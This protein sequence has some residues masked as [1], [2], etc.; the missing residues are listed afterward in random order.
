MRS[1]IDGCVS[2]SAY[3]HP[4]G[5]GSAS[6]SSVKP[7]KRSSAA[8]GV[9]V[10]SSADQSAS[11]S[12]RR[13]N[14]LSTGSASVCSPTSTSSATGTAAG[15]AIPPRRRAARAMRNAPGNANSAYQPTPF[16]MC[17]RAWCA[18]SCARTTTTSASENP[19]SNVSQSTTRRLGPIP[20]A[21]AFGTDVY[22]LTAQL[23][24]A[25]LQGGI[26]ERL[27]AGRE[28]REQEGEE[29]P[30]RHEGRR[31][32]DPPTAPEHTRERHHGQ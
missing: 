11:A 15:S 4:G 23:P 2:R 7:A 6:A 5:V 22:S 29:R 28:V 20:A 26:V 24:R 12:N 16:Q 30:E 19:K 10:T 31:S 9:R 14:A 25:C 8:P 1:S 27:E 21:Q 17:S 18:S 13:E 3:D 32:G